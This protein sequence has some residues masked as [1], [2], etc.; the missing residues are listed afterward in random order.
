MIVRPLH[1]ATKVHLKR[2]FLIEIAVASYLWRIAVNFDCKDLD[3]A[4]VETDE[5]LELRSN[6]FMTC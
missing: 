3:Q 2:V 4:T 1:S 6:F 5:V